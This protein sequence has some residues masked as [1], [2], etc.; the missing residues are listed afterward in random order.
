M[1]FRK[2]T[3]TRY[4]AIVAIMMIVAISIIIRAGFLMFAE[5]GYWEEVAARFVKEDVIVNPTRGNI[6]S[7]DGQLMASSLPEYRIYMDFTPK[8]S[9]VGIHPVQNILKK[10]QV[11]QRLTFK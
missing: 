11:L 10:H 5:R 4:L 3:S 8:F 2:S 7:A 6:L 9:D 1:D